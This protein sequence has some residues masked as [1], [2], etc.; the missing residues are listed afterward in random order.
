MDNRTE[1]NRKCENAG[2]RDVKNVKFSVG[3]LFG[4][5][6]QIQVK[7]ALE[8]NLLLRERTLEKRID[9]IMSLFNK[10]RANSINPKWS[11]L[12]YTKIC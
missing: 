10:I 12:D 11:R 1:K 4:K 2:L 5:P 9:P 3:V 8:L 6:R 7:S